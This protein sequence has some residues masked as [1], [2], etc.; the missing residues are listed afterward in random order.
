MPAKR[1]KMQDAHVIPLAAEILVLLRRLPRFKGGGYLFSAKSGQSLV[2]GDRRAKER[3]DEPNGPFEKP[4]PLH[5]LRRTMR[6]G[7][8]ALPIP[9]NV[10]QLMIA[11][12]QPNVK[13][14]WT[15]TPIWRK[16]GWTLGC[17]RSTCGGFS[18]L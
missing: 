6:T 4:R 9:E 18:E 13:K 3:I 16:G 14:A 1:T 17:G 2:N 10:R 11:H 12:A 15:R 8:S 5:D 7:L